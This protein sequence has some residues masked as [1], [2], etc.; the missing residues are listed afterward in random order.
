VSVLE[1]F[2]TTLASARATFGEGVPDHFDG[3]ALSKL[4]D[5]VAGAAPGPHWSGQAANAYEAVNA[6]HVQTLSALAE[7]D[8]RIAPHM[9]E[10]ARV[11]ATGRQELDALRQWVVDL[12]GSLPAEVDHDQELTPVVQQAT[13]QLTDVVTR[14]NAELNAI[15]ARIQGFGA[16]YAAVSRQRFG[17]S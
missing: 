8:K 13:R 4:H 5:D 16:E 1:G 6:E 12:A 15:G 10:A 11:V 7:L 9:Q 2:L 3:E 17:K 14:S